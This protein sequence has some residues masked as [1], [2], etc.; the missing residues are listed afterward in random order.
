MVGL[1]ALW[2]PIVVSAV[3]ALIALW[4]IHGRLG[5]H[6]GDVTAL[7]GEAKVME[8][9]AARTYSPGLSLPRRRQRG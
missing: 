8:C 9:C 6:K 4:I 2:V 3:F 7:P 1:S 5:W